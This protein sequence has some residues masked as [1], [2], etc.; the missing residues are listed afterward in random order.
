MW[1]QV[2]GNEP[3]EIY[4]SHVMEDLVCYH[5]DDQMSVLCS[6]NAG[7]CYVTGEIQLEMWMGLDS[8]QS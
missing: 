7:Y 4:L 6:P 1:Q 8:W 5:K 2:P 3:A